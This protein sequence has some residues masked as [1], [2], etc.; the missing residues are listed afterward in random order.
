MYIASYN[1]L[2]IT[3][4]MIS[5]FPFYYFC[6]VILKTFIL[7][8]Q[9]YYY[10]PN[11][12]QLCSYIGL[13]LLYYNR[14]HL[15]DSYSS[16]TAA[17]SKLQQLASYTQWLAIISC[18]SYLAILLY[19]YITSYSYTQ[20]ASYSQSLCMYL[21]IQIARYHITMFSFLNTQLANVAN[22]LIIQTL[23]QLSRVL[24]YFQTKL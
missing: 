3:V 14:L 18:C 16:L 9:L 8:S 7:H 22:Q 23:N 15:H 17:Q 11:P 5:L 10:N 19:S 6:T 21:A 13:L 2:S 20:L 1:K 4:L 24:L 12:S